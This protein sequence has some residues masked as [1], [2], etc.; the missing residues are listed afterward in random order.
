ME[1]ARRRRYRSP[2]LPRSCIGP[3]DKALA[4][5]AVDFTNWAL[6]DGQKFAADLGY[7]P[8]PKEVVDLEMKSLAT[9]KTK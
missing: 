1:S 3:K 7:A 9:I 5:A 4:K 6:T 2:R 8:L